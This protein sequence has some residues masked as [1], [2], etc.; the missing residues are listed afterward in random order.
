ML[1][2]PKGQPSGA[3]LTVP[4][5]H[6]RPARSADLPFLRHLYRLGRERE[7]DGLNW[8]EA[9]KR[10]FCR[11]QFEAQHLDYTRRHP[12]AWFLVLEQQRAPAGR[13]TVDPTG[14]TVHLID[15]ALLPAAQ[16][17]GIGTRLLLALQD[18]AR[19][20]GKPLSLQ[21]QRG[22]DRAAALYRRLGFNID[23]SGAT[24]DNFIWMAPEMAG[25]SIPDR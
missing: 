25:P 10:D 12:S 20:A 24:H 14:D 4:G 1:N 7:L 8:P 13:L 17:Q 9:M 6:L 22:N 5:V 18:R 11:S 19:A 3:A 2:F 15:I 21:V 16:G 23:A